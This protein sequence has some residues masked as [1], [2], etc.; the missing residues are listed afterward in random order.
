MR[1]ILGNGV[2]LKIVCH[3]NDIE[4][5]KSLSIYLYG[6][7]CIRLL[8]NKQ[9]ESILSILERLDQ[10]YNKTISEILNGKRVLLK[11]SRPIYTVEKYPYRV[12][13]DCVESAHE[14]FER[15]K[16][17]IRMNGKYINITPYR[18]G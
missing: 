18:G 14:A 2:L 6:T 15:Y 16:D 10:P 13:L 8:E 9:L 12:C 1:D 17:S 3:N 5:V 7:G 11:R 4:K